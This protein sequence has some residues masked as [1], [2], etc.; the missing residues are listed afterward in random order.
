MLIAA[1]QSWGD[2]SKLPESVEDDELCPQTRNNV[3]KERFTQRRTPMVGSPKHLRLPGA[4][5]R[6]AVL[7]EWKSAVLEMPAALINFANLTWNKE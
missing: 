1:W 2:Q 3:A 4:I 7:K 5:D 6:Q